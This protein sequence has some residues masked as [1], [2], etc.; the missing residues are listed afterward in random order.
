MKNKIYWWL[1][2]QRDKN[3]PEWLVDF[4]DMLRYDFF[5]PEE[6]TKDYFYEYEQ[7]EN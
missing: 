2:Y 7:E 3:I 1:T 6:F 5:F 4:I